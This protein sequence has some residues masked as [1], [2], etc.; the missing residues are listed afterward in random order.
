MPSS[1][2]NVGG[3]KIGAGAPVSVQSMTNT[4]T[5]DADA[6]LAQIKMLYSSGCDIVRVAVPDADAAAA[7]VRICAESPLPVVADI[8]F[9]YRLA[10]LSAKNG[11]A[12]IRVNP[13]NISSKD[14]LREITS[15]CLDRGIPIRIGVNA[16]SLPRESVAR[17]G[18]VDAMLES[19]LSQMSALDSLGFYDVCLSLKSSDVMET[20]D[21]Y[22]AVCHRTDAPLHLGVTEAGTLMNGVIRSSV[23]IGSLLALGVGDTI[24]VSLAADPVEEVLAGRAILRAC[25][26]LNEGA[27]VIACPTCGR[28]HYD[29]ITMAQ[30]VEKALEN[31]RR[32]VTVAVMGC[33]VNGPGEAS[34]ADVGVA[35][36]KNCVLLF[37]KGE[38]I[39]KVPV[40][41]AFD[42]LMQEIN[43]L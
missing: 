21:A 8:H 3:V 15:A 9:D 6:T 5:R 19:A 28:C 26:L 2:I 18:V 33:E 30:R 41:N 24:R 16:G 36:G 11:A 12:K 25:G 40:D 32:S 17:L 20:I 23:G 37:K 35:G 42:R 22:R 7:M 1:Q 31:E 13:G 39:E 27:R 38:I 14:K 29:V 4:D 34:H 10:V 43:S